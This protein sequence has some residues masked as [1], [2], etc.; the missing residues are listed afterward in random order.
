M[1]GYIKSY[2][3]MNKRRVST[4]VLPIFDTSHT[5]PKKMCTETGIQTIEKFPFCQGQ[6]YEFLHSE[7]V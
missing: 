7:K 5:T 1:N 4:D 2:T 3:R 6:K